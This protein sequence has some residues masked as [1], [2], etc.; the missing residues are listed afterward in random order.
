MRQLKLGIIVLLLVLVVPWVCGQDYTITDLGTLGGPTSYASD[1]NALGQV[2]GYSNPRGSLNYH[3]F[4]WT[5]SGG[6]QDLG[7][8]GGRTS[9]AYGLNNIGVWTKSGG[10]QDLGTLGGTLSNALSINDSGQVVGGSP[11]GPSG[12]STQAFLW[13]KGGGFQGLGTLGGS[14]S[15]AYSINSQGQVVGSSVMPGDTIQHDFLWSQAAGMKDVGTIGDGSIPMRIN[16]RGDY[17]GYSIKIGGNDRAFIWTSTTGHVDLGTLGG[18]FSQAWCMN[19]RGQVVGRSGL[20]ADN[21]T[22][23]AFLWTATEGMQDLNKFLHPHSRWVLTAATAINNVGQ[24]VGW[25]TKNGKEE[26]AFLLT[27]KTHE[28]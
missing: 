19:D 16:N 2:V 1:I 4:F 17:V 26:R 28:R 5:R 23:H 21:I 18:G 15:F 10:M 7:T 11:T 24:I 25:G 3:A 27:P 8:L 6:M 22:A 9:F 14:Y 20:A 12:L 13:T